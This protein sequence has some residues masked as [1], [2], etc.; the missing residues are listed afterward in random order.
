[1]SKFY[2]DKSNDICHPLAYWKDLMK[3]YNLSEMKLFEAKRETGSSYFFC[4]Q[5]GEVGEVGEGCGKVC[6]KYKPNNGK[7]GRCKHYGYV[8]ECTDKS[9]IIKK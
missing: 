8:Y 3:E 5:F 1:M 7:S 6:P 4:Q 2:F 9:I